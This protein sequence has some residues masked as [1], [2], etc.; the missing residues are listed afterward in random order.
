MA[1]LGK[2][3]KGENGRERTFLSHLSEP[4]RNAR[5][6]R[7]GPQPLTCA[8]HPFTISSGGLLR[9]ASFFFP[10]LDHAAVAIA[11]WL[12]VRIRP[13]P[14]GEPLGAF[15][16]A[17]AAEDRD[18]APVITIAVRSLRRAIRW[19]LTPGP[20]RGKLRAR[21]PPL[22]AFLPTHLPHELP[23][24]PIRGIGTGIAIVGFLAGVTVEWRVLGG[25]P[26]DGGWQ[27]RCS[28]L[29]RLD[30]E[31]GSHWRE[32]GSGCGLGYGR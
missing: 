19:A 1:P 13:Q 26:G 14:I 30:D 27:G 28:A 20:G 9:P 12:L 2:D 10:L 5:F 8:R 11:A 29:R 7:L 21:W 31:T 32:I 15:L 4:T 17:K 3:G 22:L 24:Q 6:G 16:G 18:E 23:P 25:L